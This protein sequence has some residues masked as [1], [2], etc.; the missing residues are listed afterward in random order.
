MLQCM[1]SDIETRLDESTQY[2]QSCN[3]NLEVYNEKNKL[4]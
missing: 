1:D 2:Y 3:N 4:Q